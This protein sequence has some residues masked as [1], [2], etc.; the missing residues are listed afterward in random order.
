MRRTAVVLAALLTAACGG[1]SGAEHPAPSSAAASST[2]AVPTLP[3]VPGMTGEAVRQRTDEAIGGQFQVRITDTG[4]QPF[5][6]TSV[7]LDSPGFEPLPP[8]QLTA[9]FAPGRI[10]DLPTKFGPVVC[11][12]DVQPAD[13]Q[14]AGARITVVRPGA[15][16]EELLVPLAGDVLALIHGEECAVRAVEEVVD[17]AVTGLHEEGDDLVGVIELARRSGDEPVT[18]V[19]ISRSVLLEAN[20]P[21]L[22]V[23]MAGDGDH[24]TV[25]VSFTPK[26]CDPHV[27]AE[28]KKPYVF[29]LVVRIGD[30]DEVPVDLPLDQA[31][32][33]QLGALVDRVCE[34]P[35]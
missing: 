28:T 22:P 21:D 4:D 18:A 30:G 29:P 23:E 3:P 11:D 10:I 24:V 27:L 12:S 2:S 5:T 16:P 6:V 7:A 32:K 17:I 9:N 25:A 35:G 15:A 13:V 19:R 33:D 1:T 31:A 8:K 20:A 34:L 14:P 26:T